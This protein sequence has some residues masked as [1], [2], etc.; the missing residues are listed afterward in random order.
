MLLVLVARFG[1]V[2]IVRLTRLQLVGGRWALLA[3]LAQIGSMVTRQYYLELA[4]GTALLLAMFCWQNRHQA[5]FRLIPLGITLNMLVI[6]ANGGVMPISPSTIEQVSGV[7]ITAGT[8]LHF[9]KDRVLNDDQAMLP[10]LSDRLLLPGPLARLAAWS[11]GDLLLLLGV[12]QLLQHT[13]KGQGY[14]D[15]NDEHILKDEAILP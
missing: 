8:T 5:G 13:M 6:A 9:S 12:G 15:G 1:R 14:H 11:I 2:G 3:G 10:W 4:L 7:R